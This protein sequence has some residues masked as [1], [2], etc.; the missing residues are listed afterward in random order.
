MKFIQST[1]ISIF[2]L[3]ALLAISSC[4]G[5][6]ELLDTIPA[7]SRMVMTINAEKI[8]SEFGIKFSETGADIPGN[9]KLKIKPKDDVDDVLD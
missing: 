6:P 4:S 7:N 2:M 1:L 9:L 5:K 3:V 8:C